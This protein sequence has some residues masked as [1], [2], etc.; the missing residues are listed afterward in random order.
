VSARDFINSWSAAG[1][2]HHCAIGTGHI[3]E[4][5]GKLADLLGLEFKLLC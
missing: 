1:P 2:S 3:S 5:I 4:K